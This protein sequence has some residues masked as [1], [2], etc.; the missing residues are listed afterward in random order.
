[1]L[2]H[3]RMPRGFSSNYQSIHNTSD[4]SSSLPILIQ[5]RPQKEEMPLSAETYIPTNLMVV[6]SPN[7]TSGYYHTPQTLEV[8]NSLPQRT[9][10]PAFIYRYDNETNRLVRYL[11]L[12]DWDREYYETDPDYG[13]VQEYLLNARQGDQ[14][15]RVSEWVP[16]PWNADKERHNQIGY[17]IRNEGRVWYGPPP[18]TVLPHSAAYEE[19]LRAL[20]YFRINIEESD[21]T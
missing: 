2:V 11:G 21:G 8:M 20:E 14:I 18:M 9:D 5:T 17:S 1:M 7:V 16:E 6:S 19:Y 10:L 15:N 12:D 13:V 3:T 4:I